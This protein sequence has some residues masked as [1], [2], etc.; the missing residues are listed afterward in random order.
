MHQFIV[1]I[2][3]KCVII[4]L[5]LLSACNSG[6]QKPPDP[7]PPS[8]MI[9]TAGDTA[10]TL[11]WSPVAGAVDQSY[12]VY[13]SS[14]PQLTPKNGTLIGSV[15]PPYLHKEL[16][17]GNTYYYMVAA[18]ASF[19]EGPASGVVSATPQPPPLPPQKVTVTPGRKTATITWLSVENSENYNLYIATDPGLTP[20]NFDSLTEGR[21][22]TAVTSPFQVTGLNDKLT[23][24][25][26]V[27]TLSSTGESL[28][29]IPVSMTPKDIISIAG[30]GADHHCVIKVEG[31]L[32]CWGSNTWGQLGIGTKTNQSIPIQIGMSMDWLAIA[33]GGIQ[34]CAIKI[35]GSL[36]CWG[37][38]F[39]TQWIREN[40]A[41]QSTPVQIGAD[42]DWQAIAVGNGHSC[43]LKKAGSLWCW[44]EGYRSGLSNGTTINQSLP[45]Q[46]GVEMNWQTISAEGVNTCSIKVEGSLWCWVSKGSEGFGTG[47][48]VNQT[49]PLQIGV[50][51]DWQAIDVAVYHACALK[52][53]GSLWCLNSY[54]LGQQADTITVNRY[55]FVKIG[56]AMDWQTIAVGSSHT[57][58]LKNENSLWCWGSN[59][60]G[61][62]G[63]GTLANQSI[64]VKIGVAMDWQVVSTGGD[65][66]SGNGHTC[67]LKKEGSVWCWGNNSFSQLGDGT[68]ANKS[69][70]VQI[71]VTKDW[72]AIFAGGI[73]TCALKKE[74]SIW[75]WG[76]FQLG[77]LDSSTPKLDSYSLTNRFTPIQ[78]GVTTDWMTIDAGDGHM[79]VIKTE[80]SLWCWGHNDN[81]QLGDGTR[82]FKNTP[83][84]IGITADWREISAGGWHTCGIKTEGSL[85]CWGFNLYGQLG[86]GKA[87]YIESKN[88]PVQIG[89]D[90]DWQKIAAG[91]AHTCAL[92]TEGSLW[93]WGNNDYGQ[94]GAGNAGYSQIIIA[95]VQIGTTLDW[96]TIA[97]SDS[98][99]CALK[100]EG[101][102]WCWGSNTW[103]QIGNGNTTDQ[104]KPVQIGMNKYWTTI[105]TGGGAGKSTSC[106]VDKEGSL[107]CWGNNFYGQLGDGSNVDKSLPTLV[108]NF[109]K[110]N[111]IVIGYH[112]ICSIDMEGFLWCWGSNHFGQLG[113]GSGWSVYP[114]QVM[115]P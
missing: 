34:T 60:W 50:E 36:W 11:T 86:N 91:G 82:V 111:Q 45:V 113:D 55:K 99:T 66:I 8:D 48:L 72:L 61:Q 90:M 22:F 3:Q 107:W 88:M 97:V 33:M 27:T 31:S 75:C 71:G 38:N 10:V 83:V 12:N 81:G 87:G 44:G 68:S 67:A 79:C 101:S 77:Q 69:K 37:S 80:G 93:C 53:E 47:A 96:Q 64:P 54:S 62:L 102:L 106:A 49:I 32:W 42:M 14:S 104:S 24:Y 26:V 29:S 105:S 23:Y 51:L 52:K 4:L 115:L 39:S 17:N 25:F 20:Q 35:T 40:T 9:A 41:F 76:G 70:P 112:H 114:R 108:S 95:P 28:A 74:S 16:T 78:L 84:Q 94:Q 85:W 89:I 6:S 98:H 1:G 73:Y 7:H 30:G 15:K 92:K 109:S 5:F 63:D 46:I 65:L 19:G 100:M 103:G 56:I 21:K 2:I 110:G 18:R 43:A 59:N 57:C 58:A 13:W